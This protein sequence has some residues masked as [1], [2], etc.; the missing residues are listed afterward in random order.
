MAGRGGAKKELDPEEQ[1]KRKFRAK[2]LFRA[3]GRLVMANTYWLAEAVDHYEGV[4]DVKRRVEQAVRGKAKKKQLLNI[5]DK[6][7]LNKHAEER[8]DQEKKY[9]YRIIG[10]LKCFKRYP[11]HV[12]K[13]LAA[14]T[15]FKY[16]SPGRT[17][18]RQHHEAHALYFIVT[19]DVVVSQMIFDELLQKYVS[20]DIGVMHQGDMFGEVSLL[21]NIP[22]TATVTT[23]GHCELLALMKEDFKNVLQASVQKQW[24]EVR[25]AMSAFT[26]FD[27]LDEVARREGC[28][29]AKM[30]S[31]E[32]NETLLGDGVGVANFVYFILSGR[33]Q[34]IETVQVVVTT[35]LGKSYYALYD[36]YV[37]KEE[38]EQDFDQKYFGAYKNLN[39]ESKESR[40][41][42]AS[43]QEGP[44]PDEVPRTSSILKQKK[45]TSV[46]AD[47]AE[48]A[49]KRAS[50]NSESS[51]MFSMK[52]QVLFQPSEQTRPSVRLSV[53]PEVQEK[54]A[55]LRTYFMQKFSGVSTESRIQFWFR[56]EH[57]G[58][59]DRCANSSGLHAVA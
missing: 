12:K 43:E 20:V 3:L 57:A 42:T 45:S 40:P 9:I 14:V 13:K 39:K 27:A 50:D 23:T 51:N 36:P 15:Y 46:Q 52:S 38:S 59:Q 55:N 26:Y 18:V 6:A 22:R 31:Y 30:K 34:M 16:Y 37:P 11:N 33:C 19:G 41:S 2:C 1:M 29:V 25:D 5:N 28:I 47:Q 53:I 24:D 7:L 8:T 58:S 35:H 56:G 17:I 48:P 21:H 44:A 10:G 4:E 32:P 54:P 49:E